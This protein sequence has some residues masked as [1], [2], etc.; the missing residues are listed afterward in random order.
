MPPPDPLMVRVYLPVGV[1]PPVFT[2]RT[3]A[4]VAGFRLKPIEDPDGNPLT[5]KVTDPVKPLSA[6]IAIV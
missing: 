1:P 4:V 5:E 2:V 6:L 3:E